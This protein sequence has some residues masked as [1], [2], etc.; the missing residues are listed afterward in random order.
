MKRSLSCWWRRACEAA[1]RRA[2]AGE[3]PVLKRSVHALWALGLALSVAVGAPVSAAA[4]GRIAVGVTAP[5]GAG[6]DY[7]YP[8]PSLFLS[9]ETD[10]SDQSR[11][12]LSL[13]G[14]YF[15]ARPTAPGYRD[16]LLVLGGGLAWLWSPDGVPE[17]YALVGVGFRRMSY[18]AED[19]PNRPNGPIAV[20]GGLG[21]DLPVGS[22][23]LFAELE[24]S[25]YSTDRG[26]EGF[27]LF[28][29]SG[30]RVGIRV[31]LPER[32]RP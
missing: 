20:K 22:M 14:M 11:L 13:E 10:L 23:D 25:V 7:N 3:G 26:T 4:Q 2:N 27:H 9:T 1:D 6:S 8:A 30:V 18:L 31:R 32:D 21:L 28:T 16:D 12:R 24:G 5:T 29:T 19:N 17:V 15:Q